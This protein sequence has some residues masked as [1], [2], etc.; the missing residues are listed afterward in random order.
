MV[1]E[2]LTRPERCAE[3]GL[4]RRRIAEVLRARGCGVCK[5]AVHGWGRSACDEPGRV[6]PRCLNTRGKQ[7]E[8]DEARLRQENEGETRE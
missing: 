1:G 3:Y 5:N 6:F 4:A 7:F 2:P 8:L